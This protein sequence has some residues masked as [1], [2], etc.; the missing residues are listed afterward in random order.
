MGIRL[1]LCEVYPAL[2]EYGQQLAI[3]G[4]HHRTVAELERLALEQ[5]EVLDGD[6]LHCLLCYEA[7]G[8]AKNGCRD[9]YRSVQNNRMWIF[10]D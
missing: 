2:Y 1:R 10:E 7:E 8:L 4:D 3:W 9:G 6:L 5:L